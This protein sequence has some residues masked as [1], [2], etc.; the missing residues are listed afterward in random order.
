ME[1]CREVFLLYVR[2]QNKGGIWSCAWIRGRER[3]RG[4]IIQLSLHSWMRSLVIVYIAL[5][6][7]NELFEKT[8]KGRFVVIRMEVMEEDVYM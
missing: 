8:G 5:N 6:T 1:W 4:W 7:S 2:M 3:P